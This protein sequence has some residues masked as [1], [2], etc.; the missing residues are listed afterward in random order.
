MYGLSLSLICQLTS[1]D[2]K[3]HYLPTYGKPTWTKYVLDSMHRK[4]SFIQLTGQFCQ[5][6]TF[7][8][9]CLFG[10]VVV[11]GLRLFTFSNYFII[12]VF[13]VFNSLM[14]LYC[15]ALIGPAESV[16]VVAS[17]L[18]SACVCVCVCVCVCARWCVCFRVCECGRVHRNLW[19]SVGHNEVTHPS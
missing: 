11:D 17:G 3:Q 8:C 13:V 14:F 16:A 4:L 12:I 15:L 1:E 10:F 2:I 7:L 6:L 5:L 19:T 18:R 9:S